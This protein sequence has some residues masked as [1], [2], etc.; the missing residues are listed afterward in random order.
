MAD[1]I[2]KG[3]TGVPPVRTKYHFPFYENSFGKIGKNLRMQIL[4]LPEQW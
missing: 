1:P 4:D 2:L 3:G